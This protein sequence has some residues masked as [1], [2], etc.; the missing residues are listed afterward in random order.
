MK[1]ASFLNY[2]S[3]TELCEG[4]FHVFPWRLF[5]SISKKFRFGYIDY[6]A[7]LYHT[8]LVAVRLEP[9]FIHY[10]KEKLSALRKKAETAKNRHPQ[11]QKK[12]AEKQTQ[13]QISLFQ[14]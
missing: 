4:I 8:G 10:I 1:N 7:G 11:T 3:K 13:E 5:A 12:A 6:F 9:P 2:N 14:I